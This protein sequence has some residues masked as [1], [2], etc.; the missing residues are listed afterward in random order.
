MRSQYRQTLFF[1]NI[2]CNPFAGM[3]PRR[4]ETSSCQAIFRDGE[5]K[6]YAEVPMGDTS[7]ASWNWVDFQLTIIK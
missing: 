6:N 2:H 4:D 1:H 3:G 5:Q 7:K